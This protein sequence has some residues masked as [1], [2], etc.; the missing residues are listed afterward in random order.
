MREQGDQVTEGRFEPTMVNTQVNTDAR[1][2]DEY[3]NKPKVDSGTNTAPVIFGE[4][5]PKT[6]SALI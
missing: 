3:L 6:Y 4:E 2:L 5:R 1:L